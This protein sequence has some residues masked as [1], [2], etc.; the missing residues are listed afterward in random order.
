MAGGDDLIDEENGR[1]G[2]SGKEWEA[3]GGEI[4]TKW[5]CFT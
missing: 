2:D 1:G 4:G 3:F 5:P